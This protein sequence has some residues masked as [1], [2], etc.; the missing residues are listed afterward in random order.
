MRKML[1]A[2]NWKMNG[3]R[4]LIQEMVQ[5]IGKKFNFNQL[6]CEVAICPPFPLLPLLQTTVK[7]LPI[8]IGAQ[9][10]YVQ[11]SGAYTGE[12]SLSLLKECD[13]TYCIVGHSE[14]RSYFQETD[15][16]VRS[17][18]DILWNSNV[19]PIFCVGETLD[20]REKGV[21]EEVVKNQVNA[22]FKGAKK[23]QVAHCVIA[24]EPVWAIGTGKTATPEQA[25]QMHAVIRQQVAHLTTQ[26]IANG[27]RILY[28][29]SVKG[30]NAKELLGQTEIDGALV[31]GASLKSDEFCQIIEASK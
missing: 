29:G 20:Q 24:Y 7:G 10:V 1:I 15:A 6:P 30:S 5:S 8:A 31:G 4:P 16:V 27:V 18:L 25:N 11:E 3:N 23:E 26:E 28:G 2:G 13:T 9:N 12:T 17:K 22:G 19:I 21:H 14:R